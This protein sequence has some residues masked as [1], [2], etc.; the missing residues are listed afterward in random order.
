MF[1]GL[2]FSKTLSEDTFDQWLIN[3]RE[4]KINY[5]FM[6]VIWE[7]GEQDYCPIYLER[8]EEIDEHQG[9]H[10]T[11]VAAYHLF[12]ETKIALDTA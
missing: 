6:L 7:E 5:E 4:S 10:S 8:R 2:G 12:S 3:G 1:D 11:V 9:S